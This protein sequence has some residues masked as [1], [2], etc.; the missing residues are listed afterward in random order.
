MRDEVRVVKRHSVTRHKE[1]LGRHVDGLDLAGF[2]RDANRH[3]V[4]HIDRHVGA[5]L[6]GVARHHGLGLRHD[7]DV[8]VV[9]QKHHL[10]LAQAEILLLVN[11]F[12]FLVKIFDD[13]HAEQQRVLEEGVQ[14]FVTIALVLDDVV[15]VI[16]RLFRRLCI[17]P[18]ARR[19]T[20]IFIVR[21][22]HPH[23]VRHDGFDGIRQFGGDDRRST[24]HFVAKRLAK[25][26]VE[27]AQPILRVL[28]VEVVQ[29]V[30]D[31]SADD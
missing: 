30:S 4:L 20:N 27:C 25:V 23:Q 18:R 28:A 11:L 13:A 16:G 1:L 7:L 8:R 9:Q 29:R 12:D 3:I 6:V 26:E 14:Q 31:L 22:E 10:R 24:L 19:K 2:A 17:L 5:V 15:N 21:R